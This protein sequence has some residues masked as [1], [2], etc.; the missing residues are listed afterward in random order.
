MN[1]YVEIGDPL[2]ATAETNILSVRP[3]W[4]LNFP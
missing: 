2:R 3:K 1:Y 4:A